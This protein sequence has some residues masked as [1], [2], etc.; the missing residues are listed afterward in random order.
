MSLG[1]EMIMLKKNDNKLIMYK[2]LDMVP[3]NMQI[4]NEIK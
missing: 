4:L 2:K 3:L 1:N